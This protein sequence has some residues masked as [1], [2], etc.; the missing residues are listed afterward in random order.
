ML[1]DYV[2][3][4]YPFSFL[5][6]TEMLFHTPHPALGI[7]I[8]VT[9]LLDKTKKR[10]YLINATWF[11]CCFVAAD[12]YMIA[13]AR[14]FPPK[15]HEMLVICKSIPHLP[16]K[17]LW[18]RLLHK[19][20]VRDVLLVGSSVMRA[21][22]PILSFRCLQFFTPALLYL[23][24]WVRQEVWWSNYYLFSKEERYFSFFQNSFVIQAILY[25]QSIW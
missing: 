10:H 2:F 20:R 6:V 22:G 4:N 1:D 16:A 14:I 23:L 24:L 7:Y 15:H 3:L 9:K 13:C 8:S 18:H 5:S 19:A 25:R 17:S 21:T 12:V 11:T